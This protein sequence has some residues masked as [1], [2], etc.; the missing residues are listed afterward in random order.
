MATPLSLADRIKPK[1]PKGVH[2]HTRAWTL[3]IRDHRD[4]I[5]KNAE[6]LTLSYDD[7]EQYRYRL[8]S[9]LTELRPRYDTE[10]LWLVL[11]INELHT[12][13]DFNNISTLIL[14]REQHI[15]T[16]NSSFRSAMS[17]LEKES[18]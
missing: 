2:A 14:P 8:Y 9:Y 3:F 13:Q 10:L 7:M 11:W 4:E 12:E 18:T 17:K 6:V 5:L 15:K 16:L 1:D